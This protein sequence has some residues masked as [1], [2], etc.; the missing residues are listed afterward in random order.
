MP[1][2]AVALT[3]F[4]G[5]AA[6]I[7]EWL[8]GPGEAF[9]TR[10]RLQDS[11]R[12]VASWDLELQHAVHG[13]QRVSIYLTPDFPATPPQVRFD[14][15]LCLVL[16]HI[17]EDGRFCHGIEADPRDFDEP[18]EVM[19]EVLRRLEKFWSD[20]ADP[21]WVAGE[22][23]RER[24]SYWLRFCMQYKP[25][26]G[27]PGLADLRL[28]LADLDGPTEGRFASYFK[29]DQK[30]RSELTVATVG[31]VDPHGLAVRHGWAVGTLVRGDALFVPL[32]A[33]RNWVPASWPRTLLELE[34]LVT[35]V[36]DGV[37]SM[38]KWM[39]DS[40]EE[41]RFFLVVLVQGKTC[42]AYLVYPAP[43]TRL[44]SPAVVPIPV[45]RVDSDWALA[46]DHGLDALHQR[47]KRRV[48]LL[49]CGSLGA[50]VAEL[51]ARAGIGELHL[52]D[53]EFFGAENCARH[54]LGA[55]EIGNLKSGDL[56]MRLRKLVPGVAVKAYRALAT[57]WIRHQCKPGTY[58]LIVDCTGE[59]AVRTVLSRLRE[60]SLGECLVA[61]VWMEPF[62]AAAHVVLLQHGDDWPADDPRG[63]VNVA[64]WPEDTRVHLPACNAGFHPYGASDVWQS[65]GFASERL[66]AALDGRVT[67][68]VVCSWVRSASFFQALRVPVQPGPLVPTSDSGLDAV[69]LTR[70]FKDVFD[71]D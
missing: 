5:A 2:N 70:A 51:L 37:Q 27:A 56:A 39:E 19:V 55:S 16:P 14:R 32:E 15:S 69:Q 30:A 4:K 9:A 68:S 60:H 57:D 31:E 71:D 23:Q 63:K 52:L 21:A 34:K 45:E 48:L 36:T 8:D 40:K 58:D 10:T 35:S 28:A 49:G 53:K 25:V 7:E 64:R 33:G 67:N 46:R 29:H 42:Y 26:R 18:I 47:R 50:P 13:S 3:P 24:L 20:S 61:H 54:L 44:T 65:A 66:L 6:A 12:K 41:A 59:S 1:E 17:E 43:V 62:C 38:S 22:F 11:R